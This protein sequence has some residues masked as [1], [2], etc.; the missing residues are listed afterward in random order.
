MARPRSDEKRDAILAAAVR[1]FAERGL[2]APTAAI[3]KEAGV[4]EGTLFTYFS[5][6]DDLVNTLYREVK[7]ELAGALMSEFSREREVRGKLQHIWECYI[8]WGLRNPDRRKLLAHLQVYDRLTPETKAV[9][10]APFAE[11]QVMAQ[12]AV[13]KGV[14]RN[15]PLEFVT[16]ALEALTQATMAQM[17][18]HPHQ[19]ARYR[20]LGFEVFWNG[21]SQK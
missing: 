7:L 16:A 9:G 3:S 2:S 18:A 17:M 6:K 5:T 1:V 4:A 11:I 15:L 21:I 14:I 12:E 10:A 19:A 20:T 13:A 8:N